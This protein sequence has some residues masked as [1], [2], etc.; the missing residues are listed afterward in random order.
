MRYLAGCLFRLVAAL[1]RSPP[2][3]ETIV[4]PALILLGLSLTAPILL[5]QRD[6]ARRRQHQSHFRQI[7]V[8]LNIYH[9][10]FQSYPASAPVKPLPSPADRKRP[11]E[12]ISPF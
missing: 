9:D 2:S 12:L 3:P 8:A 10:T 5:Q 6:L 1:F 4:V 7:G 11:A